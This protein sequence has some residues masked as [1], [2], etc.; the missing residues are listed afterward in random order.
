MLWA[1]SGTTSAPSFWVMFF[2]VC[3]VLQLSH[4]VRGV[5]LASQFGSEA[6]IDNLL[7][8]FEGAIQVGNPNYCGAAPNISAKRM[9]SPCSQSLLFLCAVES[10]RR[11][12]HSH[13][14]TRWV[15]SD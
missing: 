9:V 6:R 3:E 8:D 5:P 12:V 10:I 2:Q 14:L 4:S 7:L 13:E 1:D 11:S 15:P